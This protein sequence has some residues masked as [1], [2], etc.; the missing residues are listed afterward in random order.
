MGLAIGVGI[1]VGYAN[2]GVTLDAA[3]AAIF[4]A[5]T[6]PPSDARKALINTAVVALKNGGLWSKLSSLQVYAAADNQAARVDW[7]N[8]A[9]VAVA[10]NSPTFTAN[11]GFT[12]DGATSYID[13]Q[14]SSVGDANWTSATSGM[15][16][17]R[18]NG[19]PALE[20]G[21]MCGNSR[22]QINPHVSGAMTCSVQNA[23]SSG[24]D[25]TTPAVA[26][27]YLFTRRSASTDFDILLDNAGTVQVPVNK[28][29]SGTAYVND[30]MLVCARNS[31]GSASAFSARQYSMF[32]AGAPLTNGEFQTLVTAMEAYMV[33]VGNTA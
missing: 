7:A 4:D 27:R 22:N 10:V 26:P 28:V 32:V 31:G 24:S 19:V 5:M 8:P 14:F 17:G 33:G 15:F 1:G 18:V 30:N 20:T 3:A 25:T 13:T 21:S 9:R 11:R 2:Q 29:R 12:G 23:N 6:T 16:G